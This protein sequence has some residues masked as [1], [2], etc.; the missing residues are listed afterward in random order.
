M[1]LIGRGAHRREPQCRRR[2]LKR[3]TL[4]KVITWVCVF[5]PF[6]SGR[7][8]CDVCL[9]L[10]GSTHCDVAACHVR[11]H[12]N[13]GKRLLAA[14]C[15]PVD[16]S[17]CIRMTA[18]RR[19][20]VKFRILSSFERFVI[21]VKIWT[22]HRTLHVRYDL[23]PWLVFVMETGTRWGRRNSWT[24]SMIHSKRRVSI[25]IDRRTQVQ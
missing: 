2:S 14:S 8:L 5:R 22:T 3:S 18:T 9:S 6:L 10:C 20:F 23:C 24:W 19:I 17:S 16:L 21:W 11:S 7:V 25:D 4:E 12:N 13:C 15:L 1:V